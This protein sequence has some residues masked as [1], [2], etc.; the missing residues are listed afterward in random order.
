MKRDRRTAAYLVVR[1]AMRTL[2]TPLLVSALGAVSLLAAPP[3]IPRTNEVVRY[4]REQPVFRSK[5]ILRERGDALLVLLDGGRS[6]EPWMKDGYP[7][8]MFCILPVPPDLWLSITRTNGAVYQIGLSHDGGLLYLPEGLFQV[9]G[10]AAEQAAKVMAQI[11]D[12]LRKEIVSAPKPCAYLVGTINDG[13]TLSG[14]ARLFYGDARKWRQIYEANRK[15]LKNPDEI[16]SGM[17][18]TIPKLN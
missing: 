18:L 7:R 3:V 1:I 11:E 12:D 15:R 17:R 4:E 5:R 13:G 14:I 16:Q 10:D 2:F 8:G 6:V 9:V